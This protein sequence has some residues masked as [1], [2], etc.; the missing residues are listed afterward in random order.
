M[1]D[2]KR[3]EI[4]RLAVDCYEK[5]L[6]ADR[7][8]NQCAPADS[9]EKKRIGITYEIALAELNEAEGLLREAQKYVP[10]QD[11]KK[12]CCFTCRFGC[13]SPKI[14]DNKIIEWSHNG[15][16]VRHAPVREYKI[17]GYNEGFPEMWQ[18]LCCGDWQ[19]GPERALPTIKKDMIKND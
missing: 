16:C 4:E 7:M 8:G 11:N 2:E 14:E 5:K 6:M 3:A 15:Q 10:L 17:A 1:T 19:Q 12:E 18:E 9:E 13:F